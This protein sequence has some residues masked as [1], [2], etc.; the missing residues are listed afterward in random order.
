VA[1]F[2]Y[3]TDDLKQIAYFESNTKAKVVDFLREGETMCFVI[4]KGDMGL[5]IGKGGSKIEAIRK[6]TG[7]PIVVFEF[8]EN[9]EGFLKNLLYPVEVHGIEV[10]NLPSE[11][12]ALVEISVEDRARAV[13]Q[14]GLKLKLMRKLAKRHHSI[15]EVK[16]RAV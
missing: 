13:G 4:A 1:K 16:L 3:T 8:D 10:S 11:K 6:K 14:R 5:A 15:D 12:S 7:K 9:P 2:R